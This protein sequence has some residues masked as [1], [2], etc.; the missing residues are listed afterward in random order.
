MLIFQKMITWIMLFEILYK[1]VIRKV[2]RFAKNHPNPTALL[3]KPL[4]QTLS[5]NALCNQR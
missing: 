5:S 3:S 2:V 4:T 1:M